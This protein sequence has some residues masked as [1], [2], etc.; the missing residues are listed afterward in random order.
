MPAPPVLQMGE[1]VAD[2]H[3]IA[4]SELL[5]ESYKE[6]ADRIGVLFADAGK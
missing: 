6:L 4:A 3:L 2:H 5:A 1:W